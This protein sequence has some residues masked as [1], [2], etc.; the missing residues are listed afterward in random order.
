[1]IDLTEL[2]A[3]ALAVADQVEGPVRT[4]AVRSLLNVVGTTIGAAATAETDIVAAGM[5]RTGAPGQVPVPGRADTF[6]PPSAALITGFAAHLD[7]FDDTHLATVVHPGAATLGAALG[8]SWLHDRTGEE[9]LR[10]FA[11]GIE[12]QLRVA[13]AMSPS[14]YDAGWHITGTVGP[15][16][17][18]MAAAMLMGLD[19]EAT[20]RAIG[21]ASSMTIGHR[22]GFGT[23]N[24]P[25]HPGKAAAN[26]LVAATVAAHGLTASPT[27]LDGPRGYFRVLAPELD[28]AKLVDGWGQRWELLDNTYK[29]Y[30]CGIVSHP[31]IEAAEALHQAVGGREVE[32]VEVRCHPLVVELTGNPD[33]ADGLAAR[34]STVHG[35]ACG[36]LDGPV[37]LGSY[38]DAH[39]RSAPVIAMRAKVQLQPDPEVARAAVA[40]TATLA[41]GSTETCAVQNARGS[42]EV[43]LTD[44]QLDNKVLALVERTLPGREKEIVETART[45]AAAPSAQ[46]W[47]RALADTAARTDQEGTPA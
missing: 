28:V 8:A 40:V 34:F 7:D 45:V 13:V 27:A 33:P 18:A 25:L 35:V 47:F 37:T 32:R 11:V 36:V 26:G 46:G 30:P 44:D 4:E 3:Q 1:M 10:A 12:L 17:A 15:I 24:K 29:P 14:H 42:L 9:L 6:D 38:D 2:A 21:V 5:R 41:D 31:A 20:G 22:E 43:P 19:A 16:G 39:V 23:M